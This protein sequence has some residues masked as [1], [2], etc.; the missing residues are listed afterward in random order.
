M[1]GVCRGL[2]RLKKYEVG[3]GQGRMRKE[4]RVCQFSR[5]EMFA[6]SNNQQLGLFFLSFSFL[7]LVVL[8]RTIITATLISF[9][10]QK[11][12]EKTN[13]INLQVL[14]YVTH[15][16]AR[17]S[18]TQLPDDH[19][20]PAVPVLLNTAWTSAALRSSSPRLP[21]SWSFAHRHA[22]TVSCTS[23]R[24]FIPTTTGILPIPSPGPAAKRTDQATAT[25]TA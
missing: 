21:S 25:A 3:N 9:Q 15:R 20:H 18:Q 17:K 14:Q 5:K 13:W 6:Y 22:A 19:V 8:V 4:S 1:D 10:M 24:F 2:C 23:R 16:C 11:K 7:F 12:K